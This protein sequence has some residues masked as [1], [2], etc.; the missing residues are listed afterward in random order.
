MSNGNEEVMSEEQ[1][2]LSLYKENSICGDFK[3]RIR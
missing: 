1:R 3:V 2:R